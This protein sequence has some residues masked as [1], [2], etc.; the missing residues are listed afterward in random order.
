MLSASTS[1]N[2]GISV[3]ADEIFNLPKV[4]GDI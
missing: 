1:V 4:G 3:L 2:G